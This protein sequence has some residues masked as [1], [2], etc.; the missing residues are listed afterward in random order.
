MPVD[1]EATLDDIRIRLE[2]CIDVLT[3]RADDDTE[4]DARPGCA[5]VG[6]DEIET[7]RREREH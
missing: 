4:S 5:H 7:A 3:D 1:Y 6:H 2:R